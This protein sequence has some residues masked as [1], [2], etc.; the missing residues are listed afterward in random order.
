MMPPNCSLNILKVLS[1]S[2]TN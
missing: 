1:V 2:R